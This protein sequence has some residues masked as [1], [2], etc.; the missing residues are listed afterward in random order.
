MALATVGYCSYTFTENMRL[1]SKIAKVCEALIR[2][3]PNEHLIRSRL[4]TE[5][6]VFH[7]FT[8]PAAAVMT[9]LPIMYESAKLTGDME[10][11]TLA[12]WNCCAFVFWSGAESL[13]NVS[14]HL[15]MC[16]KEA[17]K[18][19]QTTMLYCA[20]AYLNTCLYL[21]GETD[22]ESDTKSFDELNEIGKSTKA[23]LLLWQCHICKICEYFFMR[24]YLAVISLC[25]ANPCPRP[26]RILHG[27][28]TFFEG[29]ACLSLARDTKQSKWRCTG[30]KAVWEMSRWAEM[31]PWNFESRYRLLQAEL[32]YLDG[33]MASAEE[34]YNASVLSAQKHNY[35]NDEAIACELYGI[36][37]VERKSTEKGVSQLLSALGKYKEW[38]ATKKAKELQLFIETIHVAGHNSTYGKRP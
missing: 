7:I 20:M 32:Y 21:S 9:Q 13:L 4:C 29:V 30:E 14:K 3:N 12:R 34:A 6:V 36:H 10:S 22:A 26:K 15:S 31:S 17:L 8:Q 23:N 2:D 37:L 5:L 18:H 28:R 35:V 33:D 11:A 38:G 24:D 19:K 1:G 16:I 25:E 27:W